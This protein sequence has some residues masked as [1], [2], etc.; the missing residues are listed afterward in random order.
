M[1]SPFASSSLSDR[2]LLAE[3]GRREGSVTS[4]PEQKHKM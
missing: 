4:E 2:W 3:G 1:L